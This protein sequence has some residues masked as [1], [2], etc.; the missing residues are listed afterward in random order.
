MAKYKCPGDCS[1][2]LES[3]ECSIDK[4]FELPAFIEEDEKLRTCPFYMRP[5]L[6]E[7]V[8]KRMPGRKY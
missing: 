7:E 1:F 3:G 5:L 6:T 2:L 8:S 4:R